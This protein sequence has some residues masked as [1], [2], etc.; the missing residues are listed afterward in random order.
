[1]NEPKVIYLNVGFDKDFATLSDL[2]FNQLEGVAWSDKRINDQDL[3]FELVAEVSPTNDVITCKCGNKTFTH[4]HSN[5][6]ECVA[7]HKIKI[8]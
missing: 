4:R 8:L 3:K 5:W 6:I 2:D 1:M 7:C